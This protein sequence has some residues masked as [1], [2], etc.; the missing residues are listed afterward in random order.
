M[1]VTEPDGAATREVRRLRR[2]TARLQWIAGTLATVV[3]VVVV[4]FVATRHSGPCGSVK[5]T[6][7]AYTADFQ[8]GTTLAASEKARGN[9]LPVLGPKSA[10]QLYDYE[11]SLQAMG[12]GT[13]LA[14]GPYA[15]AWVH[16]VNV[17]L[18]GSSPSP[19]RST[20]EDTRLYDAV[21][22]QNPTCFSADVR[23]QVKV[24]EGS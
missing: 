21:V 3:V 24:N 7:D 11:R 20:G 13:G 22:D 23:A 1:R 16:A 4:A 14:F 15:D 2:Q 10:T 8:V 12:I 6:A 9:Q 18:Q 5:K 17:Y 19:L